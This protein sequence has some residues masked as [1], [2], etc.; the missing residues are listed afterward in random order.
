ME[1]WRN[2]GKHLFSSFCALDTQLFPK[3]VGTLSIFDA[4]VLTLVTPSFTLPVVNFDGR[5]SRHFYFAQVVRFFFKL[6]GK[7]Q[8]WLRK[9]LNMCT[10]FSD[11]Y[12]QH[13][14][15]VEF[16]AVDFEVSFVWI[17]IKPLNLSHLFRKT[18]ILF[19]QIAS[20]AEAARHRPDFHAALPGHGF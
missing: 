2:G 14:L 12:H 16:V 4:R 9:C 19:I 11:L 20:G 1:I 6:W 17:S 10:N 7:M 15:Q 3:N 13:S 5:E 8:L 18:V